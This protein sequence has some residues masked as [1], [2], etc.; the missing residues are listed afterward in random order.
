MNIEISAD[1]LAATLS[2]ACTEG[3][4]VSDDAIL[5]GLAAKEIKTEYCKA[6]VI[7]AAAATACA[8]RLL[9]AA[10]LPAQDG[11]DA[12]IE[13]LIPK[14]R[15]RTPRVDCADKVD[16]RNLGE[17]LVVHP[18]T[19]L[20]RH[21]RATPGVAGATV[22]GKPVQPK[23]GK[24][25]S[26]PAC[27]DGTGISAGDRDLIVATITGHAV[28]EA[29]GIRVEPVYTLDEVNI[30][31]GNIVFE[32]SV[33]VKGDVLAGMKVKASGDIEIHGMVE[34]ATLEAGG[35]IVIRGGVMGG[36]DVTATSIVCG[37][38]FS[39]NHVQQARVEAGDSIF[40]NDVTI[41]SILIAGNGIVVGK[42]KRGLVMGGHLRATQSVR[43]RVLGSQARLKTVIELG[44]D[45]AQHAHLRELGAQRGR[46]EDVLMQVSRVIDLN[47]K[48]PG[49]LPA[50]T[51]E[52]A[53]LT[54]EQA[55]RRIAELRIEEEEIKRRMA[56]ALEA[57]VI[58]EQACHEGVL[59]NFG[60]L[61]C[62]AQDSCGGVFR[63]LD[64]QVRMLSLEEG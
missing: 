7:A 8:D 16:F 48:T 63:L 5:A 35:D 38:S 50:A 31:S 60:E 9:V 12:W 25:C 56:R 27:L 2:F 54:A 4:S 17:I 46:E 18:D 52:K 34:T 10:G 30:A 61:S 59:I 42:D 43:A 14:L 21:H 20:M 39:A 41:Q 23:P 36:K 55:S 33:Q 26:P 15:D 57:R 58:C 13:T 53:R 64:G 11:R 32:G 40:I 6:D 51:V 1:G 62:K 28:C 3:E 19:P 49:R 29:K 24:A 45:K 44:V 22:T 47:A 37:G